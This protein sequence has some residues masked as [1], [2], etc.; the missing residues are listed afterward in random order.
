VPTF[1][2]FL[3]QVVVG[4]SKICAERNNQ[5]SSGD[6]LPPVLPL[7]L[8]SV[9]SR[10]FM[11]CLQQQQFRLKHKLSDEEDEKID[12]Q[13]RKLRLAFKE[14]RG[15]SQM[16][17]NAQSS[18]TV[19]SFE[20]CWS[21]LGNEFDDLRTFCGAI[22]SVM[23]GTSTVESDFSLINWTKDP[24]SQ[25]LTDLLSLESILHCKQYREL[26]DSFD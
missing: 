10:D 2:N 19:Q 20:Q 11:S 7:D 3:L 26:R 8:C 14:A 17:Q 21:P 16:L 22:A 12:D 25:S 18:S 5:N 4:I 23:P 1:A 9:L 6:Q 24:N 15:F 13:F